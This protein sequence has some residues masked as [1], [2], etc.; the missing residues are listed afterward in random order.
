M[1]AVEV[2]DPRWT[3]A[4]VALGAVAWWGFARGGIEAAV[5]GVAIGGLALPSS[6]NRAWAR[7]RGPRG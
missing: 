5:V 1:V 3:T 6:V 4:K 2:V 7:L